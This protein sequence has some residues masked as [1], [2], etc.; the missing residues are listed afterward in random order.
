MP[1]NG[2]SPTA[3]QPNSLV[4]VFPMMTPPSLRTRSTAGASTAAM[5][6]AETL[7]PNV[8]RTP[9]IAIRSLT[10][11]GKP[12]SKP[13]ESLS[14]IVLSAF[15]AAAYATSSVVVTKLFS[16]GSTSSIRARL[17]SSSSTGEISFAT[18][19]SRNSTALL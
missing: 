4:V 9:P 18:M 11:I 17:R 16:V 13:G 7:D 5:L 8:Y 15:L 2:L 14:R 10:E 19:R 1:V 12:C 6:S 3:L